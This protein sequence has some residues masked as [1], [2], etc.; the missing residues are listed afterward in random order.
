MTRRSLLAIIGYCM[1]CFW[2]VPQAAAESARAVSNV[3]MSQC[4][5][6]ASKQARPDEARCPGFIVSALIEARKTCREVGGKLVAMPQTTLSAIDVNTDS[7]PEY[8]FDYTQNVSC[9]GAASAFDCGSTGCGLSLYGRLGNQWQIIGNLPERSA[10]IS[11][12]PT[13]RGQY[14]DLRVACEG[15]GCAEIQ[16]Y[17]WN[18]KSYDLAGFEVRGHAVDIPLSR[19]Q[20]WKFTRAVT[21]LADPKRGAK[22]LG[23]YKTDSFPV[24]LGKARGAPY[25]YVS[26]CNACESGFVEQSAMRRDTR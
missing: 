24:I 11:T 7:Q 18:G 16:R 4:L 19:G 12:L 13:A 1:L 15:A 22:T 3:D 21:V 2:S 8:L 10:A 23:Q 5:R 6:I 17:E 14:A 20:I 26:P 25:Y 9:D